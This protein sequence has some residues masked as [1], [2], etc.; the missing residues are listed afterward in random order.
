[1]K[2]EIVIIYVNDIFHF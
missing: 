2:L 1:M